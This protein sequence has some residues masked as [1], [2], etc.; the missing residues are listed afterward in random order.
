[1][2]HNTFFL[3]VLSAIAFGLIGIVLTLL[4]YKMFDAITPRI[5]VQRELAEK[6]NIAVAIVVGAVIIAIAIVVAA[7]ISG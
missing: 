3:A 6:H 4:G 7:A 1:M 2:W 5:D